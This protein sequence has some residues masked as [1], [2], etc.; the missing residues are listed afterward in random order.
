MSHNRF[1]FLVTALR[2]DDINDRQLRHKIDR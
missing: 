1:N 2:F